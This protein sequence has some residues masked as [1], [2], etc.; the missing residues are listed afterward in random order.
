MMSRRTRYVSIASV[1]VDFQ[2]MLSSSALGTLNTDSHVE[3]ETRGG[4]VFPGRSPA[5]LLP[6]L[7]TGTLNRIIKPIVY[8][9]STHDTA[10]FTKLSF[11]VSLYSSCAHSVE[12]E[13]DARDR[14]DRSIG[15]IDRSTQFTRK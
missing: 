13:E 7:G 8:A 6:R 10:L 3:F 14:R 12:R 5:Y 11:S 9:M 15:T 2:A 1:A 4:H